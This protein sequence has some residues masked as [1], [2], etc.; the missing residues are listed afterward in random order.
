MSGKPNPTT[1]HKNLEYICIIFRR[2]SCPG[3]QDHNQRVEGR[4]PVEEGRGKEE[5]EQQASKERRV[6]NII[7]F[8]KNR[9][10]FLEKINKYVF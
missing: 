3:C 4:W 1:P 10:D 2:C 5:E 7:E 8:F 9:V 6:T